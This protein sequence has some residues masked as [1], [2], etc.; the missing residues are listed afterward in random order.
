MISDR[1]IW[2]GETVMR[3]PLLIDRQKFNKLGGFDTRRFFLG[4][5]DHDL[6]LRGFNEFGYRCGFVPV[7]FYSPLKAGTTRKPR[8]LRSELEILRKLMEIRPNWRSS[9]LAN[10]TDATPDS[11][12]PE[13]IIRNF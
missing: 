2:L 10:F 12:V 5:D 9:S 8:S 1:R 3:G 11:L 6:A 7:S 13:T 4:Y